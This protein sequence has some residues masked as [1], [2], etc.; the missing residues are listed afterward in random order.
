[1]FWNK[2]N[3]KEGLPDL[4]VSPLKL[5]SEN[6]F[7]SYPEKPELFH[8]DAHNDLDHFDNEKHALPSFPDSP[9][10]KGF[11]QSAIK[12][13]VN[14][15]KEDSSLPELPETLVEHKFKTIEMDEN[16]EDN[17]SHASLIQE[18]R[19]SPAPSIIEPPPISSFSKKDKFTSL[20][21]Q[22]TIEESK[23]SL[24]NATSVFIKIDKF[25]SA[26]KSLE[27]INYR[28]EEISDL[29]KKIRETKLRE[30][31]ELSSWE[32]E[33]ETLKSRIQDVTENIFEKVE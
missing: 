4:P 22:P 21:S 12:E 26:R 6:G 14:P 11:S 32:K 29:L 25:R 20:I 23:P 17:F 24:S 5:R 16:P 7:S 28:I 8:E 18:I 27:E 31:Q 2:K 10:Q 15:S 33:V 19:S 3:E 9:I 13:A 30:E 1:M